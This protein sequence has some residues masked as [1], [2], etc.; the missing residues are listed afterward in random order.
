MRFFPTLFVLLLA[1]AQAPAQLPDGAVAPDFTATDLNGQSQNLYD[2]LDS[3][4][5]VVLENSS[6]T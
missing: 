4:K 6:V 5:V 3:G 1:V 2:L